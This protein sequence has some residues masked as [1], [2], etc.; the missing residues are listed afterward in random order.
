M[1]S[2]LPEDIRLLPVVALRLP[3]GAGQGGGKALFIA[4][5]SPQAVL[6]AVASGL[7]QDLP[8]TPVQLSGGLYKLLLPQVPVKGFVVPE[9]FKLKAPAFFYEHR[10]DDH[11]VV[12]RIV[13]R[14]AEHR[15]HQPGKRRLQIQ[16]KP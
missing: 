9:A 2:P 5:V 1:F 14:L 8:V 7:D 10:A 15:L 16:N 12:C 3:A 4:A 11:P 6:G 13:Q